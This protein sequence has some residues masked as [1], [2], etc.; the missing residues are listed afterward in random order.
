MELA[1]YYLRDIF[2]LDLGRAF[3]IERIVWR[4][5]SKHDSL[6]TGLAAPN[7]N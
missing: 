7:K 4:H 1:V 3:E 2:L 5:L 6:Y